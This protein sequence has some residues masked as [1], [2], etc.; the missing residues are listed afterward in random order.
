M[1]PYIALTREV[2]A[3]AL[4]GLRCRYALTQEEMAERL[5]ISC[6]AY[7]NLER[8]ISCASGVTMCFMWSMMDLAEFC[9]FVR[10]FVEG[11]R[12]IERG[13]R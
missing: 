9:A 2:L 13:E 12:A 1:D 6:R 5:R 8:R 4:F 7:S 11:V 3:E 10:R